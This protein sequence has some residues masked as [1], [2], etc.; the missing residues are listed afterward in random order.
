YK[1]LFDSIK[2]TRAKTTEHTTSLIA[3]NNKFKAQ[4]QEK[5]FAIAALKNVLRKSTGNSVSTKFAKS[6]ILGKPMSQPFRNQSVVRQPTA[7]KSERP[8]F[9]KPQCDSQVDVHNDLSKPVTT[10]Y[11]PK[12]REAASVKPHHM[13]ASSN[14]RISSKNMTRFSSND[15]VHNHYIEEAKKRTQEHS[16]NSEPS[17]MT[18]ARSQS[19]TNGSKPMPRRTQTSR[20]WPAS[21]NSFVTTKTVPI[22]EHPRNSKN[23]SCVT[24]FLKEVNSHA[25]VPSNKTTNRNKPV[26]QTGVPHKQERQIP[27]GHS[28][29]LRLY[30]HS[31]EQSSSKLVLDVVPQADKTST[32]RQASDYDDHD[33]VPQRQ[34]VSSLGDEHVPS[35]QELDMLFGPLYDEF[36]NTGS[37]LSTNIQSTS[38]P[39]THTNVHAE[40]NNNDQAKDGEQ[41]QDDEFTNPLCAPAQ[42][43]AESSSHNIVQTR[44]QLV[45]DPKMCMFALTVSIAELENIKEAMVDSAWIEAMQDK[46][47]QF[48]RLQ[49]WEL[50][51]KPFGKSIIRLKWL[52]KNKKDEDQTVIRNKARLVAKGYAQEEGIDFEES[53]AP[54]ARLEAVRIFIA[55]AA[56][57][58]PNFSD[59]RDNGISQWSSKGGDADHAGCIDSRKSTFWRNSIPSHSNLMQPRTA[60]PYQAHHFIKE[61]D[62]NGIIELYFVRT[63]YQLVDMFTKALPEDRFKYL[64]RRIGMRCLT[65]AELEVLA[66]EAA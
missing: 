51:D 36:F 45:T 57:K 25:K 3:T 34:D 39:S 64:V 53:F 13:I 4:L 27:T 60:L 2:I 56:H 14:S 15:M 46:L 30:D 62:E 12:E 35:Q 50:V 29:E 65:P 41:I 22:A 58:S 52:W 11:L 37:N 48:D 7:F 6:S 63:E 66:K 5:G 32:S 8:R 20:N 9:S 47:H 49:V 43:E 10:H 16:R 44:R 28:S 24:K 23:D 17:L 31:N 54:V 55:Y 1:E 21:K 26:E 33:P 19:T 61:Q 38:A 42:E 18:S 40:E 59:R